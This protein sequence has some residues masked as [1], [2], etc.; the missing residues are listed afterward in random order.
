MSMDYE[1][2]VFDNDFVVVFGQ[3]NNVIGLH[4]RKITTC[5]VIELPSRKIYSGSSIKN[6]TDFND[7]WEGRRYAFKRAIYFLWIIWSDCKKTSIAFHCF[8]QQFRKALGKN[9]I[10]LEERMEKE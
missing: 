9:P 3:I 7:P 5:T 10:Y 8:W 1:I 6:P 4:D 2:N